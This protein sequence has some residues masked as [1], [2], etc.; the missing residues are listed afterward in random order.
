[1]SLE[2]LYPPIASTVDTLIAPLKIQGSLTAETKAPYALLTFT[3]IEHN[4]QD[5]RSLMGEFTITHVST[6]PGPQPSEALSSALMKLDGR[7][8]GPIFIRH[9]K[10]SA[11]MDEEIV[12]TVT[13]TFEYRAFFTGDIE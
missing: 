8:V 11:R 3:R 6:Y 9:A 4:A 13:H 10:K 5:P 7:T 12:R 1:M 2:R